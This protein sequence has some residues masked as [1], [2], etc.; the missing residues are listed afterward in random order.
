MDVPQ[1]SEEHTSEHLSSQMESARG[2]IQVGVSAEAMV[3]LPRR[4]SAID[5]GRMTGS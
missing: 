3:F 1:P 2:L 4:R 5:Q